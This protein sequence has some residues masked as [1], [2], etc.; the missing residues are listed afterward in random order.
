MGDVEVRWDE[1]RRER[2]GGWSTL[3]MAEQLV[4]LW[5]QVGECITLPNMA[6][7]SV[8]VSPETSQNNK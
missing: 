4:T 8:P 6:P 7:P 1:G 3:G 2:V 5:V